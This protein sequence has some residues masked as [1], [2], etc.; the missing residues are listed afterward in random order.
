MLLLIWW[1]WLWSN[2]IS[3][4]D[5]L[6]QGMKQWHATGKTGSSMQVITIT[7]LF[8][9]SKQV[10]F[11]VLIHLVMTKMVLQEMQDHT[12]SIIWFI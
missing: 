4:S 2:L 1:P 3:Y 8:E 11:I 9:E 12:I 10:T 5:I 7:L 6:K